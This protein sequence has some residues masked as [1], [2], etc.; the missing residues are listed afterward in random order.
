MEILRGFALSATGMFRRSTPSGI[1]A[2]ILSV[3][4]VSPE[5][6]L[7]AEHPAGAFRGD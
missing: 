1:V 5:D 3:S 7:A 6:D 2:R 4:S